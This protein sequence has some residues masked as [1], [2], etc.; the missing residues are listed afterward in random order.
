MTFAEFDEPVDAHKVAFQACIEVAV[1]DTVPGRISA[2][3]RG[4]LRIAKRL[5]GEDA[6]RG[7]AG[8]AAVRE[9]FKVAG[10][11]AVLH[12]PVSFGL[13]L[14]GGLAIGQDERTSVV[15]SRFSLHGFPNI[16]AADSSVFPAAPGINPALTTMALSH[17]AG[18]EVLRNV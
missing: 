17:R 12:S 10:A 1:Q 14:M 7:Q 18:Q 16:Y 11:R 9:I 4:R 13:H 2:D 3:A 8:M 6:R 15:N 5:E